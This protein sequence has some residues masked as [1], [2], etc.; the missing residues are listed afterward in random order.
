MRFA[1]FLSGGFITVIVVNPPAMKLAKST[2]VHSMGILEMDS[3]RIFEQVF[4][5]AL[6]PSRCV[7]DFSQNGGKFPIYS[8]EA[9]LPGKNS[10]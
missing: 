4:L 2:C 8:R 9:T 10:V 7:T 3:E 6:T 1:S 5:A